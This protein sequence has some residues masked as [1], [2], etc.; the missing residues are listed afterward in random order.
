VKERRVSFKA[1]AVSLGAIIV[2][3]FSSD[4]KN[5][6]THLIHKSTTGS[7][8][9]T[10]DIRAAKSIQGCYIVSP[11]WLYECHKTGD[12]ADERCF[13]VITATNC[14]LQQMLPPKPPSAE[15]ASFKTTQKIDDGLKLKTRNSSSSL[16]S[17]VP[18]SD[19]S[20]G[21]VPD[22]RTPSMEPPESKKSSS[23]IGEILSKYGKEKLA[24]A[25]GQHKKP[26]GRLRGRASNFGGT[27]GTGSRTP[28][29]DGDS[30]H[31]SEQP[32]VP[33][34]INS[35]EEM[36]MEPE[37]LP[38]QAIGYEDQGAEKAQRFVLA[39][40]SGEATTPAKTPAKRRTR[41]PPA[42]DAAPGSVRR[43]RRKL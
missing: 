6:I 12:R 32:E 4:D 16:L 39:K 27:T 28:S 43:S 17:S 29:I 9:V 3:Q 18:L 33:I 23:D 25:L 11:D 40:L 19:R 10:K 38:S 36:G 35:D 13:A 7:R 42:V 41:L 31:G 30:R 5:P 1:L 2:D 14:D 37:P 20:N 24:S 34:L 26:R 15:T 21:Q 22:N 8:D